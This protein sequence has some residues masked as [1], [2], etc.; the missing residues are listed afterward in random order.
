MIFLYPFKIL[1]HITSVSPAS[2]L[3]FSPHLSSLPFRM[4]QEEIDKLVAARRKEL[5]EMQD[6]MGDVRL[7]P[8]HIDR[9][10]RPLTSAFCISYT[11]CYWN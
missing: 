1:Y 4:D 5:T 7:Y 3:I 9:L 8:F 10:L 6:K 11:I 2:I